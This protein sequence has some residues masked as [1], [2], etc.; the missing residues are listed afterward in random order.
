MGKG[1]YKFLS[2]AF[3]NKNVKNLLKK[4]SIYANIYINSNSLVLLQRRLIYGITKYIA[5]DTIRYSN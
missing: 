3:A 4:I 1:R 5:Q 2:R